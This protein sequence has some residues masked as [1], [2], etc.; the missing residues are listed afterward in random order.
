MTT[1]P[2]TILV[3]GAG[4]SADL[5]FPWGETFK[6]QIV[7]YVNGGQNAKKIAELIEEPEHVVQEFCQDLHVDHK[8]PTIDTFLARR[9]EDYLGIGKLAIAGTIHRCEKGSRGKIRTRSMWYRHLYELMNYEHTDAPISFDAILTFNY[10]RSLEYF[11]R[12]YPRSYFNKSELGDVCKK[13]A[14]VTPLHLHGDLGSLNDVGF[15]DGMSDECLVS[16]GTNIK[17]PTAEEVSTS[18]QFKKAREMIEKAQRII[19][20]GFGYDRDN[21]S[22]LGLL[23]PRDDLV[24]IGTGMNIVGQERQDVHDLFEGKIELGVESENILAFLRRIDL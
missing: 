12:E 1:K 16:A 14:T 17:I 11:M 24:R 13:W 7:N 23:P 4:A 9:A 20:L 15:G 21:V 22:N 3:L 5:G 10:D 19:F 2:E 18:M 8:H 6:A